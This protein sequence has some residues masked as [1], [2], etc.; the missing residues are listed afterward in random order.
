VE[1]KKIK[2]MLPNVDYIISAAGDCNGTIYFDAGDLFGGVA[3]HSPLV[4]NCVAVPMFSIDSLVNDKK[5]QPP[6]MLKLDTHG[7]EV[8]ILEGA[9][10]TL[11]NTALIVV[12]VYNFKLNGEA[13]R[14]HEFCNYLESKGFSCIDIA[15]PMHRPKDQAFWQMDMF[16]VSSSN[17]EFESNTYE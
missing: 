17:K 10:E 7:F 1:L 4:S 6:F 11:K 12:E 2:A 16:F 9:R 14:F 13:L 3:S 8:P 15:D 5:L